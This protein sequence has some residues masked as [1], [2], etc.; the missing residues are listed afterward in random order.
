MC[1]CIQIIGT[2]TIA[3]S[4]DERFFGTVLEFLSNFLGSFYGSTLLF[5]LMGAHIT[6]VDSELHFRFFSFRYIGF[7]YQFFFLGWA[8]FGKSLKEFFFIFEVSSRI[9]YAQTHQL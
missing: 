2:H 7:F 5:Y 1:Q 3:S 6:Y 4:V 8:F 9:L